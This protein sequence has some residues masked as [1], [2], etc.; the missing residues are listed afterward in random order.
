[1][2]D[3]GRQKRGRIGAMTSR[4]GV[5]FVSLGVQPMDLNFYYLSD[6]V[7]VHIDFTSSN[8]LH[9]SSL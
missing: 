2:V 9:S 4:A 7:K 3:S 5:H 1:M 6:K 8:V